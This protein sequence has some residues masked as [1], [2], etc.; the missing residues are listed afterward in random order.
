MTDR[1]P[2]ASS[3]L[4]GER[5]KKLVA[6]G[7]ARL[8]V[9]RARP[10]W[11]GPDELTVTGRRVL[12]RPAVSQLAALSALAETDPD[13]YLV[14]LTD[15]TDQDLGDAVL[16]RAYRQ[17]VE[18]VDEW[19]AIAGLYD[20]QR[21]DP[22]LLRAG[23]WVPAALLEHQPAE[24]WPRVATGV[25]T[26]DHALGNLLGACLRLLLPVELDLVGL[27]TALDT[28]ESRGAWQATAEP[29]R[30]ELRHW[31]VGSLGAAAGMALAAAA[32]GPISIVA[33]GLALDVLW[34]TDTGEP[35]EPE[36]VLARG[37][38][39]SRIDGRPV[40]PTVA[41]TLA[42]AARTQ[43]LRL[44]LDQDPSVPGV[45]AQAEALLA[46]LDWPAG[47]ERSTALPAGL[48]ARHRALAALLTDATSAGLTANLPRIEGALTDVVHHDRAVPHDPEVTAARMAVR[49]ARWAASLA[50]RDLPTEL[51][52]AL[53]DYLTDGAWVD[54]AAA[55]VWN[56]STDDVVSTVYRSL[57]ATVRRL[58]D[59]RDRN[60][61]R[62]LAAATLRDEAPTGA[63]LIENALGEVV[64]PTAATTRPLV[65]LL[66]GM[67]APVAI[68]LAEALVGDGWVER[69]P[70][71]GGRFP[72]LAALPTLTRYSRTAFFTGELRD[73]TQDTETAA[74]RSRFGAP[75]FH[76]NDLR[77]DGGEALPAPV[78]AAIE[79]PDQ[80]LVATVLNTI[81]DALDK[82]DPGGTRW[83]VAAIQHLRALLSAAA[84]A[85]RTVVLT[86]DHGHVVERGSDGRPTPGAEARRRPANSGAPA[87]D[88]VLVRGR[89]V[90]TG[91]DVL[92][93][94]EDLRY[95]SLRSGY[96]GGASLAEITVPFLVFGRPGQPAAAGWRDAPPQT[97]LWWNETQR[98]A[99]PG[100]RRALR[101]AGSAGRGDSAAAP[102]SR[103]PA[104]TDDGPQGVLAFDLPE[105]PSL[106]AARSAV[107]RAF[108]GLP[109]ASVMEGLA[110]SEVY[111]HQRTRAGRH[112]L[113]HDQVV[114]ALTTL[115]DG[116]GRA[117]RDTLATALDIPETSFGSVFAALGRLLNVDSYPVIA[118]DPDGVTVRLDEALLRDQ[119]ELGSA[120]G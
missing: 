68:E 32:R 18:S 33:T 4:V 81:D 104:P 94:R 61:A 10:R 100:S 1:L 105:P 103:L 117:H 26:A 101:T 29:L 59:L 69:V 118:L 88:E 120:R 76:K 67:S 23:A 65:I 60:A 24:G 115:L 15:R 48:R 43:L 111:G 113:S 62:L 73:G 84:D 90:L 12:V 16:L 40:P 98:A 37:R 11:T 27:I 5:A 92:P 19:S 71:G 30:D 17:R 116:G 45:L 3:A 53:R 38:I 114:V 42:D 64:W 82:H 112:A 7:G 36:Q 66:D 57:L 52:A 99:T 58:R 35:D 2:V 110:A 106:P 95:A 83:E 77:S 102:P 13:D 9:L 20:A 34:P 55:V 63:V 97:P 50:E 86:S 74:M 96:H 6:E 107:E 8:L 47:A 39:E 79:N 25:V 41:R 31:A 56:G 78:R 49:L 14:L 46:D 51:G 108:A 54:R 44:D 87:D 93:W 22:A 119:F 72:L 70:D 80:R 91:E 75:L 109:G 21:L 85:G 28:P 89:R